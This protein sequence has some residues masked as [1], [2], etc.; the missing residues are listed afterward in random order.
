L[1]VFQTTIDKEE[2]EEEEEE[3]KVNWDMLCSQC[4]MKMMNKCKIGYTYSSMKKRFGIH[5]NSSSHTLMTTSPFKA[6]VIVGSS[7]R[8]HIAFCQIG[9]FC[10]LPINSFAIPGNHK[11]LLNSWR[12]TFILKQ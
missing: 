7:L 6:L 1:P 12:V 3:E 9:A 8:V 11:A 10:R 2:E 4:H 5:P